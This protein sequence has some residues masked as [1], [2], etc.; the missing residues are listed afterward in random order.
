MIFIEF[1]RDDAADYIEV[2]KENLQEQVETFT[3]D[4]IDGR[5]EYF[6]VFYV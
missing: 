6:R 3:K 5:V 2:T 1:M 4:F